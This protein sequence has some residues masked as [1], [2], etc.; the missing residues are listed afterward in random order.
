MNNLNDES[1]AITLSTL[2]YQQWVACGRRK[3]VGSLNAWE[4]YNHLLS[5]KTEEQR[6]EPPL[7]LWINYHDDH[8]DNE[9]LDKKPVVVPSVRTVYEVN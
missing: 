4:F 2:A 5:T 6:I 9:Y 8:H 7:L 3:E 1:K